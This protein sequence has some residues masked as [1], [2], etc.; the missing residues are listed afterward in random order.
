MQKLNRQLFGGGR[1]YPE[2]VLQF[3]SGNFLRAFVDWQIEKMNQEAG[4]QAGVTIVQST[5]RGIVNQLN[6]QDGLFTVYVRGLKDNSIVQEHMVV[7]CVN[8]GINISKDYQ[9]FF[10]IA[11]NPNLR[12]VI[13]NTTESGIHFE[14]ED[15]INNVPPK[16]FPGKL[17]I[18]LYE[19]FK[20]FSGSVDK[21]LIIIPCELIERNGEVLKQ[22][23]LQYA[24]HWSLGE[25]F[26]DWIHEANT[27]CGS[28]VDRI[29][30]G[31]PKDEIDSIIEE[32]GY[33]DQLVTI[34][35]PYYLWVI[36]GPEWLENEIPFQKANLN[37]KIVKDMTPY[38]TRK[39][40]ILNGVHTAMTPVAYLFGC[41]TVREAVQNETIRKYIEQLI[42][43][44]IFPTLDLP[45]DETKSFVKEVLERFENPF[46]HHYLSSIALNSMSKFKTRNLPTL[47]E[48]VKQTGKLPKNL[49]FSLSALISF[50]KGKR[51]SEP[52]ELID[53]NEILQLYQSLW[54]DYDG[55]DNY[56]HHIVQNVLAYE[57]LWNQDLND[58]PRL[59][60][61]TTLYLSKIENFGIKEAIRQI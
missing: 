31:F 2:K 17:T 57:K 15:L 61:L 29:V 19:R 28:L 33:E 59:T 4:F 1:N 25:E 16:T 50:Y 52:I 42:N 21:G 35:E 51:G 34:A 48:Y 13:S 37:V 20:F 53:D 60:A 41:S 23:V 49:V 46:I 39:V 47:L 5:S 6:E 10:N 56:L 27:F 12:F 45:K 3:G 32:L 36:E 30:P 14:A 11:R 58:I 26:F 7:T 40:R 38:R 43:E 22:T 18:L 55:S 8:R 44:E 9:Q 24:E 54:K